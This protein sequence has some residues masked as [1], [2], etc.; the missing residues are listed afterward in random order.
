MELSGRILGRKTADAHRISDGKYH[1]QQPHVEFAFP[2][3]AGEFLSAVPG[4][5]SSPGVDGDISRGTVCKSAPLAATGSYLYPVHA[6]F[7]DCSLFTGRREMAALHTFANAIRLHGS[8]NRNDDFDSL[9][10]R[11]TGEVKGRARCVPGR[12]RSLSADSVGR[13]GVDRICERAALCDVHERP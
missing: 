10:R 5:Q 3:L 12:D 1:L 7:L 11:F 6:F 4:D 9:V 2:G 13:T 8:G